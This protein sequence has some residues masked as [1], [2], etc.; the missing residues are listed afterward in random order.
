MTDTP[1]AAVRT[2]LRGCDRAT[3]AT[4][5]RSADAPEGADAPYASLVLLAVDHDAAPLLL[6]SDLADHTKN[7]QADP[8]CSLLLDGTAGLADPLTGARATLQGTIRRETG[9]AALKRF[10]RRHPSAAMYAGFGDFNLYRMEP[11]RAHLVAGFGR[12][13][14]I[15]AE[16]VLATLPGGY[17]L[18]DQESGVVEHMN[19][20]HADA[21]ALYASVLLGLPGVG[22][23]LTGVDCE[24]ADLR[25]DGVLRA[26]AFRQAGRGFRDGAGRTGAAG[27]TGPRRCWKHRKRWVTRSESTEKPPT[28]ALSPSRVRRRSLPMRRIAGRPAPTR[29]GDKPIPTA[30]ELRHD[31]LGRCHRRTRQYG[32][33]AGQNVNP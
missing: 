25:R 20:D 10:I 11:V 30:S 19:E 1:A 16:E 13:H 12:I 31:A 6:L 23:Q 21:V 14:W 24:G 29:L 17:A 3:L 5:E 32:D 22:W 7:L 18:A 9:E 15:G 8:V 2:L 26:L 27:Q 33:Q 28:V 4:R